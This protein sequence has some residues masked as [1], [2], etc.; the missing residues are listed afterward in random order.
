MT[1]IGQTVLIGNV[2]IYRPYAYMHRHKLHRNPPGLTVMG[3]IEVNNIMEDLNPIIKGEGRDRNKISKERHIMP[4]TTTS[5]GE[6]LQTSL[7]GGNLVLPSIV[8]DTAPLHIF[9]HIIYK[10]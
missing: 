3:N 10:K 5:V 7:E 8:E 1:K 9:L 6:R 2:N 4:L